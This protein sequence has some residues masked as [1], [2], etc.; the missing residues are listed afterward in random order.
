M[1]ISLFSQSLFAL[2]LEEAIDATAQVGFPA[3]ELAC[4]PP[5]F[6][7]DT[8]A[9]EPERVAERIRQRGLTVSA[10]SL[11]T[12]F[13]DWET[14]A[15]Q[16]AAAE[17]YIELAQLL[18]T[19]LLKLTPGQ[20]AS[21]DAQVCHWDCL[22]RAMESLAKMASRA[23]VRLAF[24]TH[25][26]Q[27]TDTLAGSMRLLELAPSEAIGLTV[28]FSNLSFA[29]EDLSEAIPALSARMYNAHVKNGT[30][31]EDGAW[32]FHALDSGLTEY[33]PVLA[34][35][36]QLGYDDWLAVECLG[37]DAAERPVET[38][39]RDLSILRSFL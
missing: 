24:E 28:D 31:G 18:G 26:R 21:A 4:A 12:S 39:S 25:M 32:H 34:L 17:R 37:P 8:A 35:L 13:T 1:K 27:L 38:A 33:R 9:R 19:A 2:P 16:L 22:A 20:P 23:G 5:H 10:L 7:M 36:R 30:V 29:G 14:L 15:E 3:I 11:F 6:D